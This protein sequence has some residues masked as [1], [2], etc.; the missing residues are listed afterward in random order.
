M[1]REV[2]AQCRDLQRRVDQLQDQLVERQFEVDGFRREVACKQ[3]LIEEA[4]SSERETH[5]KAT[6]L[7]LA[8]RSL[9]ADRDNVRST[10]DAK[11]A[12]L[13]ERI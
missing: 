5:K 7:E 3:Q 10:A 12:R 9:R 6:L 2:E 1:S 13:E 11:E 8:N 4:E